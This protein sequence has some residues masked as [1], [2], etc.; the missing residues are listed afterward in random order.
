MNLLCLIGFLIIQ[1]PNRKIAPKLKIIFPVRGR[2]VARHDAPAYFRLPFLEQLTET[3]FSVS[4]SK[5]RLAG[6]MVHFFLAGVFL[7]D[8]L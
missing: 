4:L 8:T 5:A 1:N 6:L 3:I 7:M 2:R